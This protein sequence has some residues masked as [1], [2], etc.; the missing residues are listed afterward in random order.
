M[1]APDQ[2]IISCSM[3]KH[4]AMKGQSGIFDILI[5]VANT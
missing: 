2:A 3:F 4:G 1:C 5:L